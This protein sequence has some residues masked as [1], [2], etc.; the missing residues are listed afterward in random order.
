[1]S[2]QNPLRDEKFFS[3]LGSVVWGF[4]V[5]GRYGREEKKALK[6]F[7]KRAPNYPLETYQQM[8]ETSL[9]VL[10]TTIEA[11]KKTP[12]RPKTGQKFAEYGDVD[13]NYVEEYLR[14]K[15]PN[16]DDELLKSH[17]GMTIYWYYLR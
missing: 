8:F 5:Y 6:A 17:I 10:Q 4:H 14:S 12:K 16:V 15:F 1:M 3:A 9:E 13:V 2:R 7:A 11:V